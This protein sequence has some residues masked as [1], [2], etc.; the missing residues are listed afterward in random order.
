MP[1]LVF[2]LFFYRKYNIKFGI[3]IGDSL[4]GEWKREDRVGS[5]LKN[6][7][8]RKQ[9]E[10]EGDSCEKRIDK[11]KLRDSLGIMKSIIIVV[12]KFNLHYYGWC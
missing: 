1:N 10:L 4:K 5:G 2:L 3:C 6:M 11:I 7:R 9:G 8:E 12:L